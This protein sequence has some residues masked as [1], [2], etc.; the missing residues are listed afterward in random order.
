MTT[1]QTTAQLVLTDDA[2]L[3][4][5]SGRPSFYPAGC[6]AAH[7]L[8]DIEGYV[9]RHTIGAPFQS[10]T[11]RPGRDVAVVTHSGHYAVALER[12]L[13]LRDLPRSYAV[14]DMVYGCGCRS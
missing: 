4:A 6:T 1:T 10:S 3:R 11:A 8:G 9:V 5:V 12:A 7:A 2:T 13:A 14:V